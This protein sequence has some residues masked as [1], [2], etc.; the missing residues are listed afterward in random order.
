MKKKL[1]QEENK[2]WYF[3]VRFLA[4]TGARV[5]E[6]VQIKVEHV[7]VG[8]YDIYTK[9]GKI[10]RIYIPKT[11]REET[12]GWLKG[13]K[14]TTGYLF[15][16]RFGQRITTRGI[17][18][19]LKNYAVKYGLNEKMNY[20]DFNLSDA[21]QFWN[22]L[23]YTGYLTLDQR[24]A[25]GIHRFRIPNAEIRECFDSNIT[26]YYSMKG[27]KYFENYSKAITEAIFDG[28]TEGLTTALARALSTFVSAR[29]VTGREPKENYYHGMLNGILVSAGD[30]IGEHSSNTDS[31]DGYA[32][33]TVCSA[34]FKVA[35]VIELK[36]ASSR[37][38][39]D[40]KAKE[41][42]RQIAEKDYAEKVR[43]RGIGKIF[44]Y[45]IAFFHRQ[46]SVAVEQLPA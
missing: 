13:L 32:D 41:A 34:D 30:L 44:G 33:I 19:Q 6:L 45:G 15:L 35:A 39:L 40:S 8:Y 22:L 31:G 42:L 1:K 14:R 17:S 4:A 16:N 18:Q 36:Y 38:E 5:S 12:A 3:V 9:G 29:D 24:G 43:N 7:Q 23:V 27:G 46:C 37:S 10:R 28:N 21:S 2:E 26:A 25:G 11:L 20:G